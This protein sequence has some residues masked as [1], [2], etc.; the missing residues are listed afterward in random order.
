MVSLKAFFNE[1][2]KLKADKYSMKQW[3]FKERKL[4]ELHEIFA[5]LRL[6]LANERTAT[7]R[8]APRPAQEGPLRSAR[9]AFDLVKGP[10]V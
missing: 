7:E 6:I 2:I 8:S 9:R 4:L 1:I 3:G 5:V 10:L